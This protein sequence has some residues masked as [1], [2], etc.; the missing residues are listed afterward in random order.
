MRATA[1]K[2]SAA[3]DHDCSRVVVKVSDLGFRV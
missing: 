2:Y 1:A 3:R